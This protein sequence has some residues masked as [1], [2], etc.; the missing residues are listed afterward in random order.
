M[1]KSGKVLQPDIHRIAKSRIAGEAQPQRVKD[2]IDLEG[3]K[4]NYPGSDK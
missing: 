1:K 4:T 2:R 3:K